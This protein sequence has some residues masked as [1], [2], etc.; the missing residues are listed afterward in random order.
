MKCWIPGP[1]DRGLE[2][3]LRNRFSDRC[4]SS[5]LGYRP[6]PAVAVSNPS[7][8]QVPQ[9][10][11][12]TRR[13]LSPEPPPKTCVPPFFFFFGKNSEKPGKPSRDSGRESCGFLLG[14]QAGT[15]VQSDATEVHSSGKLLCG[16]EGSG[17][18]KTS[19]AFSP[20]TK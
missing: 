20:F 11:S 17:K 7:V 16:V 4:R 5:V 3:V 10:C 8:T 9:V 6:C 15:E 19:K 14:S 13:R 2:D 12:R 1:V 18:T